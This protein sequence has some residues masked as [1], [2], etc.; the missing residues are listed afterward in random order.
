MYNGLVKY[1]A[2]FFTSLARVLNEE[3]VEPRDLEMMRMILPL[4]IE[5]GKEF[6]PDAATVAVLNSAAMEAQAWLMYKATTDV[7]PWWRGSQWCV[8][9]PPITMPTGFKWETP[10]YFDVDSRAIALSQYFCPTAKLGTGS[11]YFGT[12]HDHSGNPLEGK[13]NYRLH[14]PVYVSSGPS[15][16]TVWKRRAS[17]SMRRALPSVRSTR[18]CGRTPMA[19]WTS[20]LARS[21]PPVRN[22]TGFTP[23]PVRN[24]S[25]GSALMARKTQFSTRVGSCR[26]SR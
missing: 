3:T 25:R 21:R 17:S 10:S 5:K 12:F 1:D 2:S 16:F 20:T 9:S 26:T 6:K 18:T 23:K 24:G 11:F 22:P 8:P 13:N 7:T 15:P 19:R 4:G 14:V